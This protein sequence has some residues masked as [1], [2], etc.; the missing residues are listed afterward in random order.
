MSVRLITSEPG[1]AVERSTVAA[2][3]AMPS[4]ERGK[5]AMNMEFPVPIHGHYVEWDVPDYQARIDAAYERGREEILLQLRGAS[6][7]AVADALVRLLRQDE[8]EDEDE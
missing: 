5:M 6:A 3:F 7:E 4:G 1:E 8:D 2:T